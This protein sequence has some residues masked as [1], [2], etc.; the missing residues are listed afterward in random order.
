MLFE[1]NNP[2]LNYIR[3]ENIGQLINWRPND[4]VIISENDPYVSRWRGVIHMCM[5]RNRNSGKFLVSATYSQWRQ[6]KLIVSV[7]FRYCEIIIALVTSF[8]RLPFFNKYGR[9]A[10]SF[11]LWNNKKGGLRTQ[12]SDEKPR[13]SHIRHTVQTWHPCQLN[14]ICLL[15]YAYESIW[16]L[17]ATWQC[18]LATYLRTTTTYWLKG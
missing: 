11:A 12:A 3:T 18:P 16:S 7:E 5:G 15:F 14:M 10:V 8:I 4:K 13:V 6:S 9:F 17:H 1:R 2:K